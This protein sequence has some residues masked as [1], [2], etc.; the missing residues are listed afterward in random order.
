MPSA[1]VLKDAWPLS[2]KGR[3]QAVNL[4]PQLAQLNIDKV[5]SSPV[6]R[7]VDTVLPFAEKLGMN[8]YKQECLR[9]PNFA[10]AYMPPA[11]LQERVQEFWDNFDEGRE[12]EESARECQRRTLHALADISVNNPGKT[13]LVCTHA[14]NIALTL[15]ALEPAFTLSDWANMQMGDIFRLIYHENQGTWDRSFEPESFNQV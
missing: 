3:V 14:Q 9:E 6:G 15:R 12:G 1:G 4:V 2:D 5:I 8:I 11:E 13:V 10:P 7:T